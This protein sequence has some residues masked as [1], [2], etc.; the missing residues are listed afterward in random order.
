MGWSRGDIGNFAIQ[1]IAACIMTLSVCWVG[2]LIYGTGLVYPRT[3]HLDI[4]NRGFVT[5]C[6]LPAANVRTGSKRLAR[7]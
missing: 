3:S 7:G 4:T 2:R 1:I 6:S 5:R